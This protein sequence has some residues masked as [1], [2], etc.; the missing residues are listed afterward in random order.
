MEIGHILLELA[1]LCDWLGNVHD[2]SRARNRRVHLRWSC[3]GIPGATRQ[4]RRCVESHWHWRPCQ[5]GCQDARV[6]RSVPDRLRCGEVG[7]SAAVC[8]S[9]SSLHSSHGDDPEPPRTGPRKGLHPRRWPGLSHERSL[10]NSKAQHSSDASRDNAGH[11]GQHHSSSMC[12][13]DAGVS[14]YRQPGPNS[15]CHG[16]RSNHP[17]G[18]NNL[19]LIPHHGD[20]RDSL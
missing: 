6:H 1:G 2:A 7:A 3:A 11:P 9:G 14:E 16:G 5:L 15:N 19:L 10:W 12:R 18:C 8:G 17:S 20:G 4:P 13:R